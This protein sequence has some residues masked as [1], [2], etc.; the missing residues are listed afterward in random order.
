MDKTEL[1]QTLRSQFIP[2]S[3][4]VQN[5]LNYLMGD[6]VFLSE[7]FISDDTSLEDA[8]NMQTSTDKEFNIEEAFNSEA[9]V[10]NT[11]ITELTEKIHNNQHATNV[12]FE[13]RK[14]SVAAKIAALRG[15][16]MPGDY[17]NK[18]F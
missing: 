4:A 12:P 2:M 17:L 8:F 6:N 5:K 13:E 18:K 7:D 9:T 15:I 10:S 16:A 3:E 1:K 14:K 11:K